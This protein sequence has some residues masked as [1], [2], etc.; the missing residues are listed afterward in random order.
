MKIT[1]DF[2][3]RAG[4][5]IKKILWRFAIMKKKIFVLMIMT[6][7][8]CV[9]GAMLLGRPAW[10]QEK[11]KPAAKPSPVPKKPEVVI[12]LER[13]VDESFADAKAKIEESETALN[14]GVVAVVKNVR[15][16]LAKDQD[17]RIQNLFKT[18]FDELAQ[19]QMR[20]MEEYKKSK[21]KLDELIDRFSRKT[22]V[23]LEILKMDLALKK[24][25]EVHPERLEEL[26][27]NA[28]QISM[29]PKYNLSP[30]EKARL[31]NVI[32]E[33]DK[34]IKKFEKMAKDGEPAIQPDVFA[35]FIEILGINK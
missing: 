23:E 32:K 9:C 34:V 24:G 29:N 19:E 18:E 2:P 31:Q 4:Y 27:I 8:V 28:G 17:P 6:L 30:E 16:N 10:A 7:V 12:P 11:K 25:E 15:F 35:P 22:L 5:E 1:I 33:K 3:L 21:Q 20:M 14:Q 13:R 26:V